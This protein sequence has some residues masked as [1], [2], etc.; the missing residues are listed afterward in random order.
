MAGA[1]VRVEVLAGEAGVAARGPD[2]VDTSALV[3][4]STHVSEKLCREGGW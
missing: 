1:V 3:V 2:V 4:L